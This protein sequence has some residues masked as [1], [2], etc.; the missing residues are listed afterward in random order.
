MT[1]KTN[2]AKATQNLATKFA[3][4]IKNGGVVC[5]FGDLGAGKTTFSQA[6]ARAIG[7]KEN[8]VSPT[9]ILVR[10]YEIPKDRF[11][12]HVDLYRL[13]NP[14]EIKVLGLEEV[15]NDPDNVVLIE[16]PEKIVDSLPRDRWEVRINTI[17][18]NTRAI[19]IDKLSSK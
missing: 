5:L 7:V 6:V 14:G 15:V 18:K 13:N 3:E 17:G 9:F 19:T 4:E 2:S 16:W 11:F 10:R 8:V 1:A 12:W